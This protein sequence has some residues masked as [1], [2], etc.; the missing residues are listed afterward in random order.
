MGIGAEQ[1]GL[2]SAIVAHMLIDVVLLG[3]LSPNRDKLRA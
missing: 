1:V 3:A 2:I